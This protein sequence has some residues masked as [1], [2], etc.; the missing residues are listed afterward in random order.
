MT[1][2]LIKVQD[3][4]ETEVETEIN[5]NINNLKRKK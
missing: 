1:V 5:F 3:A 2:K 4:I